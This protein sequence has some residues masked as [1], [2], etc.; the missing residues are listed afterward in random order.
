MERPLCLRVSEGT[1][2]TAQRRKS[3]TREASVPQK[4]RPAAEAAPGAP[5]GSRDCRGR[6]YVKAEEAETGAIQRTSVRGVP[7]VG[8]GCGEGGSQRSLECSHL[9]DGP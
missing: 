6:G 2:T 7:G 8:V 3:G 1:H 9:T 4:G 5:K